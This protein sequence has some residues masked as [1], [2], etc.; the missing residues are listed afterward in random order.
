M[1]AVAVLR[2]LAIVPAAVGFLRQVLF[3]NVGQNVLTNLKVGITILGFRFFVNEII[4]S[5]AKVALNVERA[6]GKPTKEADIK[7]VEVTAYYNGRRI[8]AVR[9]TTRFAFSTIG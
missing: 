9:V 3:S 1:L 4:F 8:I 5:Q 2:R 7:L 6:S